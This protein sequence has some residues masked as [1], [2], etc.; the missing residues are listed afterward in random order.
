MYLPG[1]ITTAAAQTTGHNTNPCGSIA[2]TQGLTPEDP[3]TIVYDS[4]QG[5]CW[6][7]NANLAGNPEAQARLGVTGINP[8]GTMLYQTAL[9]WVNALNAYNNGQGY[10]GHNNWQLP[11]TPLVDTTCS[12]VNQGNFGVSC[13]GSAMG[14]LYNVGLAITYPDSV[15]P[16]FTSE[17]WPF[18]NLQPGLYWTSSTSTGD[19]GPST[20]SFNTGLNGSNTTVY[21]YL[22]VLPMFPGAIG[23]PPRGSGI[24]PYTTGPAAGKAVFDPTTGYSWP[25]DANLAASNQFLV[26]GNT[27]IYSPINKMTYTPPFI[28]AAA[29]TMLLATATDPTV[30]PGIDGWLAA[31]NSVTYAGTSFWTLPSLTDLQNL[32]L[33][34][35]IQPGTVKLQAHGYVGPFL[36]LQPGFYWSC[37]RDSGTTRQAPCDPNLIPVEN[38]IWSFNFDDGFEGTD[39]ISKEFYVMV[40]YPAPQE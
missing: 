5:L 36:N 23:T 30:A 9:S 37:E 38:Q 8:D 39:L 31:M 40:Y 26:V 2:L 12:E 17:F 27:S 10:L 3:G 14:N 24:M 32:Y 29:G 21:N 22:H 1:L 11:T 19:G 4:N 13:T 7:A 28:D 18:R 20:F 15:V 35:G 16:G 33:D 6:L 25:I 34:L